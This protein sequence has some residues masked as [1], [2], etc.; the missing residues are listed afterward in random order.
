MMR[1]IR[2]VKLW[3][4]GGF[5]RC[6]NRLYKTEV[7]EPRSQKQSHEDVLTFTRKGSTFNNVDPEKEREP[8][9]EATP[10]TFPHHKGTPSRDWD[11]ESAP[12]FPVVFSKIIRP[13]DVT[14]WHVEALNVEVLEPCRFQDLLPLS[15]NGTSYLPLREPQE[16]A[17]AGSYADATKADGTA[18][19]N[20]KDYDSRLAELKVDNDAGY[21]VITRSSKPGASVPRL[22]HMRKFWEGLESISQYWDCSL[23]QYYEI[24]T[25]NDVENENSAKR[26]RLDEGGEVNIAT[27]QNGSGSA[28][29][30]KARK[31]LDNCDPDALS[32]ARRKD[33]LDRLDR[34]RE[35]DDNKASE[36]QKNNVEATS[37]IRYKG[38][39]VGTGRHTPDQ[40]FVNTIKSFVEGIAWAFQC[41]VAAPKRMPILQLGRLNQPVRQSASVYRM[42]K[43]RKKARSGFLE[44]PV[45]GLQIRSETD[46]ME[47]NG[48]PSE[49]KAR[50]D[51]LREL[52]G[53]LQIAQERRREGRIEVNPGLGKWWATEPRWGGGTGGAT[54]KESEDLEMADQPADA[55]KKGLGREKNGSKS[56]P[57]KTSS[58]LWKEVKP[59]SA[60]W[61][62]KMG[63]AAIGKDVNSAYDEVSDDVLL[64]ISF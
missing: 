34:A 44:G 14:E 29:A 22:A 20:Q 54:G 32:S 38:R 7:R 45:M 2:S 57:R 17:P 16:S 50:M 26:A 3:F 21:R 6:L 9:P 28:E 53:L 35:E 46:F 55:A 27:P 47:D 30:Q 61:D 60:V 5:K 11:V 8:P 56:R 52:G 43:D 33:L 25:E 23:D 18:A 42:P 58:E 10:V 15:S 4:S 62:P 59:G 31:D 41:S 39:R 37:N 19:R 24:A 51:H 1:R 48:Q 40:F 64:L 13:V 36:N 63:H 12:D 49:V